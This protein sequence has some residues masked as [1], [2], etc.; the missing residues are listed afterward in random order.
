[1]DFNLTKEQLLVRKM[2]A[3]FTENEVK[4]IAAEKM[5]I[6]DR[7]LCDFPGEKTILGLSDIVKF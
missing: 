2:M 3:D 6:R 4:P 5:C 7:T 1:M